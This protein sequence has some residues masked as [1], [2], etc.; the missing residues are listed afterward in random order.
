MTDDLVHW[1]S[2]VL[3]ENNT[4]RL[5]YGDQS[6][7]VEDLWVKAVLK[8]GFELGVGL[9]RYPRSSLENGQC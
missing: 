6:V 9:H 4:H 5:L 8:G 2:A 7:I 1:N 3:L